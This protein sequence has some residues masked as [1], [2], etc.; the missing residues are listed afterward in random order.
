MR[1]EVEI[2]RKIADVTEKRVRE[3]L[4]EYGEKAGET[5]KIGAYGSPSSRVDVE[6]E[7]IIVNFVKNNELP[8]NIFSE[9][10]GY[11]DRGYEDTLIVDPVDGSYNAENGLPFYSISLAVTEDSLSGVKY[12]L[13]RDIPHHRDYWAVRGQGAFLENRRLKTKGDRSLFI[14]YLG[15]KAHP[16]SFDIARKARRV[17]NLGSASLE[18]CMVAEGIADLFLYRFSGGGAL[19]IVDIAAAYLI[20]REAGGMVLDDALREL[21]MKLS[22]EERKNVIAVA[23]SKVLEVLK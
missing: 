18:M 22:F 13:V 17:R 6:A 7:R 4:E 14:V 19:R 5:V 23:S 21:N 3:V 20:V 12:S 11:E 16:A 9:E 8:F 10:L 2:L 1:E 15:R